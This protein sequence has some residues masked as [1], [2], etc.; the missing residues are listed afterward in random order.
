[1]APFYQAVP[2]MVE[3]MM[4]G[5]TEK[6]RTEKPKR[7]KLK[8]IP[9][10]SA[11]LWQIAFNTVS[12]SIFLLDKKG[13]IVKCNRAALNLTGK[14]PAEIEGHFCYEL[15]HGTSKPIKGCPVVRAKQT[16]CRETLVLKVGDRWLNAS[17]DPVLDKNGGFQ[18]AVHII[19]DITECK[20]M[21]EVL[22][23]FEER[24]HSL[25]ELSPEAIAV[26]SGGKIV[27]INTAGARLLGATSP[28]QLTGKPIMDF[29]HPDYR[30]IV[31][32]RIQRL[33]DEEKEVTWIEEKFIKLDGTVIDVEVAATQIA[34][35]GKPAVQAVV[36]DI[37]KRKKTEEALR[38]VYAELK[39]LSERRIDFT[40]MA[41]H[42]LRTPL[43][44]IIGYLSLMKNEIKDERLLRYLE[45]ME[46][47]AQ[48]QSKLIDRMLDL[49]RLD[50]GKVELEA[51]DVDVNKLLQWILYDYAPTGRE[52]KVKV[53]PNLVITSDEDKLFQIIDNLISNAIKYSS[54]DTAI[55]ICVETLGEDYLFKVID[56]GI[57][58]SKEEQKRIFERFY[59]VDGEKT[60]RET[61]RTGLGLALAKG[62]VDLLGG[63]IW[64]ES[65][66]G[67]GSTFCFT[68]PR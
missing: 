21:E 31:K 43:T 20:R 44:P 18:G 15:M 36:R 66:P 40:N 64:V 26:H 29:L 28:E 63:K 67:K 65:E 49:S 62:Y 56:Q 1:M 16:L 5:R 25:V 27:F 30:N 24:Y 51:S 6:R 7:G 35:Q 2:D 10:A 13:K 53:P 54:S 48:R 37:T 46:R 59:I 19:S 23:E 4:R 34:Y 33:Y 45:I 58:I 8:E 3:V 38:K 32:E 9:L 14:T 41:A 11:D 39:E 61:K 42:E 12:D 60:T 50:A 55:K 68:I 57:G 52:I 47:N 17:V 22:Q